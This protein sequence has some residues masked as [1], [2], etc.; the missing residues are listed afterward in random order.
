MRTGFSYISLGL[1]EWVD[2]M[3]YIYTHRLVYFWLRKSRLFSESPKPLAME[4]FFDC[5]F[6]YTMFMFY[7]LPT[8]TFPPT[9]YIDKQQEHRP[10]VIDWAVAP[11][12][13]FEFPLC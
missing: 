3:F 10:G 11:R 1:I 2:F 9:N 5:T 4:L 8:E 7:I 13:I 6:L 12:M